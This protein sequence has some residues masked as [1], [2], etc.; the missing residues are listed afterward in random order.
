MDPIAPLGRCAALLPRHGCARRGGA[1][2]GPRIAAV[3]PASAAQ[4]R[5]AG[6][7]ATQAFHARSTS[8]SRGS[9]LGT[10][11][12]VVATIATLPVIWSVFGEA[13]WAGIVLTTL[14]MPAVTALIAGGWAWIAATDLF[15]CEA[16]TWC[17]HE[18]VALHTA[19][20]H[21]PGT[22][23][24][25]PLARSGRS[26]LRAA[27]RC[28]PPDGNGRAGRLAAARL[29]SAHRTSPDRRG[30]SARGSRGARDGR[31][32]WHGD[33]GP[34][35]GSFAA[36]RRPWLR[37]R[38]AVARAAGVL[39]R[40]LDAGPLRMLTHDHADHARDLPWLARRFGAARWIGPSRGGRRP[41]AG[42]AALARGRPWRG[43]TLGRRTDCES[44]RAALRRE[45]G[46]LAELTC[47]TTGARVVLSGDAEA[48]GLEQLLG[49][50]AEPRSDRRAPPAASRVRSRHRADSS[51]TSNPGRSG[52]A[53]PGAARPRSNAGAGDQPAHH[54]RRQRL[55]LPQAPITL[56]T[57]HSRSPPIEAGETVTSGQHLVLPPR[58]PRSPAPSP[59]AAP[60]AALSL[61][62]SAIVAAACHAP[63]GPR[64][65]RIEPLGRADVGRPRAGSP[66]HT[67]EAA[68]AEGIAARHPPPRRRCRPRARARP[69]GGY[70]VKHDGS[71]RPIPAGASNAR[72]SQALRSTSGSP[73]T[74]SRPLT[75]SG[76]PR[77]RAPEEAF[78]IGDAL[79]AEDARDLDLRSVCAR[80][81][82]RLGGLPE[83]APRASSMRCA[84]SATAGRCPGGLLERIVTQRLARP[85][86]RSSARIC[87]RGTPEGGRSRSS[88]WDGSSRWRIRAPSCCMRSTTHPRACAWPRAA[89][90]RTSDR[91]PWAS[92]S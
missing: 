44:S 86:W 11:A 77:Q 75:R 31:R 7:K 90:S 92:R 43:R 64:L 53:P 23:L 19:F 26:L 45:R 55:D 2:R 65:L 38:S 66:G 46:S 80:A 50:R 85:S 33:R 21:F 70:E 67:P 71:W 34:C 52:S 8:R 62:L 36:P 15:P 81:A 51:I 89:R 4:P 41:I 60:P 58:A 87:A 49:Q 9:G 32:G 12:S 25:L 6:R 59:R 61:A 42:P 35:T 73:T 30:P 78:A 20:D 74:R 76:C 82:R 83:Q 1:R 17:T 14:A 63:A 84:A 22:P 54:G 24:V 27:S 47:P 13:S 39:L 88:A 18:L 72:A 16:L 48:H 69:D 40:A 79:L 5:S 56:S 91:E 28:S 37:D 57:V 10:G 29:R 3:L 68:R